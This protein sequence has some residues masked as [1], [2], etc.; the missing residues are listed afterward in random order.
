MKRA[1]LV[2]VT[3]VVAAA[4]TAQAAPRKTDRA[5]APR[6]LAEAVRKGDA[7]LATFAA[8]THWILYEKEEKV[9]AGLAEAL[10]TVDL[11]ASGP[12]GDRWAPTSRAMIALFTSVLRDAES[13][14]RRSGD[15]TDA[16]IAA[17]VQ[18]AAPAIAA[19]LAES[20]VT[21]GPADRPKH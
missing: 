11:P 14:R 8:I 5:D 3:V 16:E 2:A 20:G 13:G 7:D 15:E 10:A 21:S 6:L 17:L 9:A 19:A 1:V 18:A 4:S 12:A